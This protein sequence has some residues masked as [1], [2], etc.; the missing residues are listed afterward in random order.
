MI[1]KEIIDGKIVTT[2]VP[3]LF[4]TRIEVYTERE[5]IELQHKS[6]WQRV[7]EK[8]GWK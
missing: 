1:Y 8:Y 5:F 2:N 6:W 4:G 7:K 3:G